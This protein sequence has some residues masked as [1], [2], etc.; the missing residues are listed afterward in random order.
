M[1]HD[2]DAGAGARRRGRV[3]DVALD[4]LDVLREVGQVLAL[5][6]EEV[7]EDAHLV[8]AREQRARDRGADEAGAAGDEIGAGHVGNLSER[9]PAKQV[10]ALKE[11]AEGPFIR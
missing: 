2:L 1:E 6:G 3:P 9:W 8:A 4:E 7:V 11:P 5:A 10:P